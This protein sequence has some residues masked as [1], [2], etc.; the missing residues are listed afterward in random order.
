M[1][2]LKHF[3]SFSRKEERPM[4][5][6]NKTCLVPSLKNKLEDE[7]NILKKENFRKIFPPRY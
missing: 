4:K 1:V 2:L 3:Q 5:P 6:A 7:I